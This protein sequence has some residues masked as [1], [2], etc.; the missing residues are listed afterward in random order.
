MFYGTDTVISVFPDP[1]EA[2]SIESDMEI[3]VALQSR[4]W[5]LLSGITQ[6]C[7]LTL[8]L[9]TVGP[10]AHFLTSPSLYFVS[11]KCDWQ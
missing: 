7:V 8:P 5:V 3:S 2:Y 4:Q 6:N 1:L 9:T 11:V 10:L